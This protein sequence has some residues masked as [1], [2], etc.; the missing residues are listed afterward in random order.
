MIF[1]CYNCLT[2]I[3]NHIYKAH[4]KNFC[5]N[6]CRQKY[7]KSN[8][9]NSNN[10][11]KFIDKKYFNINLVLFKNNT[12]KNHHEYYSKYNNIN[13]FVKKIE[14]YDL[15]KLDTIKYLYNIKYNFDNYSNQFNKKNI[16]TRNCNIFN[17]FNIYNMFVYL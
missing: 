6:T 3:N 13:D 7:L 11:D 16:C 1:I 15:N 4:D 9:Y 14:N 17:I 2:R 12:D 10:I 5:C 8:N